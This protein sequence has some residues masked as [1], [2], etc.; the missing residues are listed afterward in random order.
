MEMAR[1]A[2]VCVCCP[3]RGPRAAPASGVTAPP[4]DTRSTC[5]GAAPRTET[6]LRRTH[7]FAPAVSGPWWP[8]I[9][10]DR[11]VKLHA[12]FHRRFVG[13]VLRMA[14]LVVTKQSCLLIRWDL[15]FPVHRES[16]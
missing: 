15:L 16:C 7:T 8:P 10:V 14:S 12:F 9:S 3:C 4:E 11:R 13:A 1:V 6:G 2:M 5:L